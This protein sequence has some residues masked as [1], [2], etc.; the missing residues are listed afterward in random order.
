MTNFT[1]ILPVEA[2]LYMQTDRQR[3][4]TKLIIAFRSHANAAKQ[5]TVQSFSGIEAWPRGLSSQ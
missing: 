4:M 5:T 3:D 1:K 2:K